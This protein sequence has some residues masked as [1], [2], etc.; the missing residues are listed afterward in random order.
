MQD[1]LILDE[2]AMM[3]PS[4]INLRGNLTVA[5]T[6][7]PGGAATCNT[8][9]FKDIKASCDW[10]IKQKQSIRKEVGKK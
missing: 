9:L 1:C 4:K 6:Y 10:K 8:K 7:L 3:T 5:Y 2:R